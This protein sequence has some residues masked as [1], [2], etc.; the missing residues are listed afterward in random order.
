MASKD[1][2]P[3]QV[4]MGKLFLQSQFCTKPKRPPPGTT[5]S[6]KTALV[7]GS[8]IGIGLECARQFLQLQVSHL[9]LGVRSVERGEKAAQSLR[10]AHPKAKIEVWALDMLSYKSIEAFAQRCQKLDRL[11]VG[12]LNAGITSANFVI[13]ESTGHEEMFQVNY[14]S[15]ALLSI[16]LL[17]ALSKKTESANTPGRLT[18]VSSGTAL[19]AQFPNHRAEPL[20]RS[21]DDG[22]S[23]DLN[24]ATD[25][26]STS[27]TLL[28]MF[29][30]KISELVDPNKVVIQAVD[31]G[32]VQGTGLHRHLG[33]GLRAMF[34][35]MKSL[36]ARSLEQGAWTYVD[37]AVVKG[38]ET[39][40]CFLM[41]YKISP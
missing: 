3:L 22:T 7:T 25:R 15:T 16:L 30:S 14:L 6:G 23:W 10:K 40:G 4:S 41:D 17:P 33:G 12:V 20:I 21:F 28:L 36:T 35:V 27:K 18:I 13:N 38:E 2:P 9:I 39:H 11:D 5:L 34:A 37:A 24:A 8:N 31:P 26:Y 19:V 32:F 1:L 29:V